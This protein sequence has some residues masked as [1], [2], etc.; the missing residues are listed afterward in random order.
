MT[1]RPPRSP[2]RRRR[3]RHPPSTKVTGRPPTSAMSEA[4]HPPVR[5]LIATEVPSERRRSVTG[6]G[7]GSPDDPGSGAEP[8]ELHASADS[9]VSSGSS[10]NSGRRCT[11]PGAATTTSSRPSSDGMTHAPS[12]PVESLSADQYGMYHARTSTE[13]GRVGLD[14]DLVGRLA[15]EPGRRF[16]D[17]RGV[18]DLPDA[19]VLGRPDETQPR[20]TPLESSASA[21]PPS[22]R[23]TSGSA[24]HRT[25]CSSTHRRYCAAVSSVVVEHRHCGP[26]RPGAP[27]LG[28][29]AP[30]TRCGPPPNGRR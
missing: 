2:D 6:S 9:A 14:H 3:D 24:I 15:H 7:R 19:P 25:A 1:T 4:A 12:S 21:F 29:S 27:T 17:R 13:P 16:H 26:C 8:A 11:N 10:E 5:S 18:D 28:R 30:P 22:S 20:Q 23:S